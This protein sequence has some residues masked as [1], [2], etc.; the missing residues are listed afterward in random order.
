LL[1]NK[2]GTCPGKFFGLAG[3][4]ERL[5]D[6]GRRSWQTLPL[7][8]HRKARL[9][10]SER[11]TRTSRPPSQAGLLAASHGGIR[12]VAGH[13][14]LGRRLVEKDRLGVNGFGQFVTLGALDILVGAP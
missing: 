2:E 6:R 4:I 12:A 1:P 10:L 14:I 13:A 5:K 3:A 11:L 9:D 7:H 8:P